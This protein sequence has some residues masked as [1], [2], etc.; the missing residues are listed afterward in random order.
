MKEEIIIA[1]FGG[2][3][4]LSMGKIIA[5]SGIMQGMEVTWMPSYGPE[6][7]GGTANVTVALSSRR[8]SSPIVSRCDAAIILNQQSMDKFESSVRS[9]GLL[10]YDPN[11]IIKPPT[12]KD[13]IVCQ[14]DA[15]EE[16]AKTG[17]A[18]TY[19]M[20]VLG[21]YLKKHPVVQLENVIKGLK[22]SIPE[23]H[24]KLIPAN[25]QAIRRGM[26]AVRE[27]VKP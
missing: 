2:Q 15:A 17:N 25:E 11:G 23:R 16:A 24:H 4:V 8:I 1:G 20:I 9:G 12:R 21:A 6:M 22:K 10:L 19:N 3:G 26:E 13:I 5:Y 14:I 18:K 27:Y 7:R